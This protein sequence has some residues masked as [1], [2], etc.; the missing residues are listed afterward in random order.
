M[1]DD[2]YGITIVA[3]SQSRATRDIEHSV[4]GII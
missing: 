3:L 4:C 2:P 1:A